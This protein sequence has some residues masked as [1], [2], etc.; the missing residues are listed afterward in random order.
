MERLLCLLIGYALGCIQTAYF[1]GKITARIDIREHGSGNA[2]T[3]N[4]T[5]V[6]GKKA[7]I[8]VFVLD[9]LKGVLAFN[10][11]MF[12]FADDMFARDA[13][14][15]RFGLYAGLGAVIGHCFP[16]YLKFKGGKGVATSLGVILF[17][18]FPMAC[19]CY[20]CGFITVYFSKYISLASLVIMAVFPILMTVFLGFNLENLIIALLLSGLIY[21]VHRGNIQRIMNGTERKFSLK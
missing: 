2:G 4:V 8:V 13:E 5:R 10:L 21:Y 3:T 11:C 17:I 18:Q 19:L 15:L 6:L 7:G 1:V 16:F 9:I 20:L 12:L 14:L